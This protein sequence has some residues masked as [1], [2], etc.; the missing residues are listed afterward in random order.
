MDEYNILNTIKPAYFR[1]KFPYNIVNPEKI[2]FTMN[3]IVIWAK[4]DNKKH[5]GGVQKDPP[6]LNAQPIEYYG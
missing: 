4:E 2:K 3:K 6:V 5:M 1:S